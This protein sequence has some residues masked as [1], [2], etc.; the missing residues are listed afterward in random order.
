MLPTEN[1]NPR[2]SE[3]EDESFS[4]VSNEDESFDFIS[5]EDCGDEE[6][7]SENDSFG[8]H[9]DPEETFKSVVAEIFK[10]ENYRVL[11]LKQLESNL[12][13]LVLDV[14]DVLELGYEQSLKL[15]QKYE[16]DK[17]VL[18]E[19]RYTK[20]DALRIVEDLRNSF[21][22]L[23]ISTKSSDCQAWINDY[24]NK[25]TSLKW[26]PRDGC[27]LAV[28]A[29][30]AEISTVK[31]LCSFEFCF[32]CD[33]APH[34]PVPCYLLAHWLENDN[35]DSLKMIM[36]E[37]KPCPKCRV[38]VQNENEKSKR[39]RRVMCPNVE[40]HSL[41][42]WRCGVLSDEVHYD[43]QNYERPFDYEREKLEMDF[44]RYSRYHKL[45]EEQRLNLE[46]EGILRDQIRDSLFQYLQEALNKLLE[47]FKTLMYSYVLEFYL[48]EK[49]Y[50]DTLEQTLKYLQDD[51][52]KLLEAFVDLQDD[53]SEES[54]KSMQD[55]C[56][57]AVKKRD[58]LLMICAEEIKN[59]NWTFDEHKFIEM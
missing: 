41:F 28:E 6:E 1:N 48:N 13:Q 49:S 9:S 46:L 42:C 53:Y 24:V 8:N 5:Y 14:D 50:T 36:C 18:L 31:C 57:N 39:W 34:D 43:C 4:F 35:H 12:Q 26:C 7:M 38:R 58:S 54:I 51:C 3:D 20:E 27:P 55:L 32:S 15:L 17:Y 45:F 21:G 52:V 22:N 23:D 10:K 40:C 16:Y 2:E 59:D 29:E 33:R 56:V 47:C 25:S 11:T 37:S 44:R 19:Q 30:Y